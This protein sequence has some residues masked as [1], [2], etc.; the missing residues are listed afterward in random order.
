VSDQEVPY[1]NLTKRIVFTDTDHRH[2]QLLIRLRHDG[3]RQSEFFRHIITGYIEG[4]EHIRSFV[5]SFKPQ[6]IK[7]KAKSKKDTVKGR[8]VA[9]DLALD[10]DQ[11]DNI[12]DLIAEEHPEL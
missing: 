7:R 6:S 12:F 4:D 11:I 9:N 1:G 3:L 10:K 5:E 2:A 8:Q